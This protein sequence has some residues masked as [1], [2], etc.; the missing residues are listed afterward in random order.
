MYD[1]EE[2]MYVEDLLLLSGGF[3][4]SSDQENLTIN[5]PKLDPLNERI[6]EKFNVQID[7][8]YLLG[9]K[10]RPDNGF[11][12]EDKDIIVIKKILGYKEAVRIELKGEV[13]FPQ[14]VVTEF[15]STTLGD[16]LD[17][18]GGLTKYSNLD[19]SFLE[20]DGK[21]ISLDFNNLRAEEVFEDGDI[22]YIASS[23]GIVS[24]TGAVKNESNFIWKKGISAKKYIRN[25]G[26]KL[27]ET[28]GKSFLVLPNGKTK[29]IGF[30]KN[31]KVLPNSIIITDFKSAENKQQALQRF[32]EEFSNTITFVTATLTSVLIATKL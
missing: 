28:G 29:K 18:A 2:N 4:I 3:L 6:I 26:G 11:I 31:P 19:A 22:V 16:L 7:K 25:S 10:D 24:T 1:L 5:R 14:N 17:Y 32:I 13:N 12:L 20:R 30:F 23:K 15:K 9:L 8:D 27:N 21:I